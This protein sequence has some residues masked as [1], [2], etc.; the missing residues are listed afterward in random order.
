MFPLNNVIW[1]VMR[2]EARTAPV[3]DPGPLSVRIPEVVMKWAEGYGWGADDPDVWIAVAPQD[4]TR[5]A[6]DAEVACRDGA[7]SDDDLGAIEAQM[8]E[9]GS[10][11]F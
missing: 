6:I 1:S 4:V 11:S 9:Q 10:W 5:G 2:G 8:V 3:V 7:V